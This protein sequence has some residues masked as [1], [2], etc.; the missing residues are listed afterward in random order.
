MQKLLTDNSI[1]ATISFLVKKVRYAPFFVGTALPCPIGV[2]RRDAILG[3]RYMAQNR[4]RDSLNL[5]HSYFVFLFLLCRSSNVGFRLPFSSTNLINGSGPL[6]A[7]STA[8][9]IN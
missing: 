7:S 3:V 8:L 2:T 5:W 6:M 9:P 4:F 1:V